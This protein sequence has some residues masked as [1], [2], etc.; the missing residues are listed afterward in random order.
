MDAQNRF[1]DYA[2]AGLDQLYGELITLLIL[3]RGL[4]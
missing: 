3:R 2:Y 4:F 1:H